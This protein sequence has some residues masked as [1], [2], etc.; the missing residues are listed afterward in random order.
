M[1]NKKRLLP[2]GGAAAFLYELLSGRVC[3]CFAVHL[4][5]HA[6][7]LLKTVAEGIH[8]R[9][10]APKS[11]IG[12]RFGRIQKQKLRFVQPELP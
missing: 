8:I 11:D 3:A 12:N 10:A 1:Q 9:K 5:R 4:R 2:K 7:I 6:E